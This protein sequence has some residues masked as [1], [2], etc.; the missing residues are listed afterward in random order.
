MNS[1]LLRLEYKIDLLIRAMQEQGLMIEALP[2]LS[3]VEKDKCPICATLYKVAIDIKSEQLQL[4][5]G[6]TAP[7]QV[8]PGISSILNKKEE[9]NASNSSQKDRVPPEQEAES[10]SLRRRGPTTGSSSR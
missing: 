4:N 8:V 6:C 3:G 9:S 2:S 1:P 5:C 7:I 10:D